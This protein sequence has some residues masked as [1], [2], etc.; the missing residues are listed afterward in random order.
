MGWVEDG[1]KMDGKAER[2]SSRQP[3]LLLPP[4]HL[5]ADD[6]LVGGGH[7]GEAVWICVDGAR[8]RVRERRTRLGN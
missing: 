1:E 2:N 8:G 4:T 3:H 5:Q 6:E 7:D